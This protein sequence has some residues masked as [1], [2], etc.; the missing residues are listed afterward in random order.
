FH[1]K[2]T[3][4]LWKRFWLFK[5][6]LQVRTIWFRIIH[7]Q[8]P[9]TRLLQHRFPDRFPSPQ[10]HPCKSSEDSTFHFFCSCPLL[11][12]TWSTLNQYFI[13]SHLP[14][15]LSIS[16]TSIQ[17]ITNFPSRVPDTVFVPHL[18]SPP[19]KLITCI[20]QAIWSSHWALIFHEVPFQPA[21]VLS[22]ALRL[23]H[24]L[25]NE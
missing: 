15:F 11:F 2:V 18:S 8:I 21:L 1:Y 16:Y 4:S 13:S 14:D 25:A 17:S 23:I 20:I 24:Q 19:P 5:I 6:N 12:Q 22:S 7:N 10:C 3:K 9:H